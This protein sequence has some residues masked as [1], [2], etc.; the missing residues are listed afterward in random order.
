MAAVDAWPDW[1]GGALALVGPEAVGKT[2]LARAWARRAGAAFVA[3]S[4]TDLTAI[5]PGPILCEDADRLASDTLLFHLFNRAETAGGLLLTARAS[6]RSWPTGL[7]DLRSRLNAVMAATIGAPDD[8]VLEGVLIR[9]F[10]ERHIKP[11][12]EL[13]GYLLRRIERSVPAARSVVARLDEVG[14]ASRREVNRTLAREILD[15]GEA[16]LDLFE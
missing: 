16:S 1:P 11:D 3:P 15:A 9:F 4:V 6:P 13:L 10:R 7:P 2:H 8:A 14:A 12:P 5:P